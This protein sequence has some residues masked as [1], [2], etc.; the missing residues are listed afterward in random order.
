MSCKSE[1]LTIV[2]KRRTALERSIEQINNAKYSGR[3]TPAGL[4]A[5]VDDLNAE[6]AITTNNER[7]KALQVIEEAENAWK[8]TSKNTSAK[9]LQDA[10]YQA[11]LANVL[12]MIR[13]GALDPDNLPAVLEAYENDLLSM[14]AVRGAVMESGNADLI[15]AMPPAADQQSLFTE[16]KK[17]VRKYITPVHLDNNVAAKMGLSWLEKVLERVN[18]SLIKEES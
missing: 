10:G 8:E 7:E 5:Y 17:T 12:H 16:M 6:N 3:Y 15:A 1:L 18:D 13:S 9:N 14:A 11:G 2:K 4:Q